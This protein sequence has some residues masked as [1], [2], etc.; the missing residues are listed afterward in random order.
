MNALPLTGDDI[1]LDMLVQSVAC[2][3]DGL[4]EQLSAQAG[5]IWCISRDCRPDVHYLQ[6]QLGVIDLAMLYAR[7]QIDMVN[8]RENSY[9]ESTSTAASERDDEGTRNST[10]RKCGWS[11]ATSW[12]Q[13]QRNSAQHDR[14]RSDST[15]TSDAASHATSW[16][17]GRQAAQGWATSWDDALST[18]DAQATT[19]A[20]SSDTRSSQSSSGTPAWKGDGNVDPGDDAVATLVPPIPH[21]ELIPFSFDVEPGSL[22]LDDPVN[23]DYV[24]PNPQLPFCGDENNPCEPLASYGRGWNANYSLTFSIP[25]VSSTVSWGNAGNFRQSFICSSGRTSGTGIAWSEANA[26]A[27]DESQSDGAATGHDENS[28]QHDAHRR[29][30]SFSNSDSEGSASSRG[31][32]RSL[33]E[34]DSGADSA[35]HSE[36]SSAGTSAQTGRSWSESNANS[37]DDTTNT[38]EAH[39][40]SQIF[41]SLNDMWQRVLSEIEQAEH[42]YKA[43]APALSGLLGVTIAQ[44]CCDGRVPHHMTVRPRPV[45]PHMPTRRTGCSSSVCST[46]VLR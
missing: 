3:D 2:G 13:F 30:D 33:G 44:P 43:S 10:Y 9:G 14:A 45:R 35:A 46:G 12:Q 15:S 34:T 11:Q 1:L 7:N 25:S 5:T 37:Y 22:T 41:A 4:R 28:T 24:N 19:T 26:T 18:S 39:Y 40:W 27:T 36:Q 16:D 32:M 31:I 21:I 29:A 38:S 42:I 6:A 20:R 23:S 8:S 17:R